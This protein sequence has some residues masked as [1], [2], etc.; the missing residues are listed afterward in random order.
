MKRKKLSIINKGRKVSKVKG[1]VK[2]SGA[3]SGGY[4]IS[5]IEEEKGDFFRGDY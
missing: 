1:R 4:R 5:G 2:G 3:Q